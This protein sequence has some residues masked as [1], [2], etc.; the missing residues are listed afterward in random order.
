MLVSPHGTRIGVVQSWKFPLTFVQ[1]RLEKLQRRVNSFAIVIRR[2]GCLVEI[3]ELHCSKSQEHCRSWNKPIRQ[4][5]T[6]RTVTLDHS[7]V[8]F[9][10]QPFNLVNDPGQIPLR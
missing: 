3:R 9:H 10:E 5:H 1:Q 2:T 8:T 6:K 4:L 7:W